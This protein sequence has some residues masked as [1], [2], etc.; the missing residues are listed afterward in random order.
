MRS[1]DS[2]VRLA[3]RVSLRT[4]RASERGFTITELLVVMVIIAVLASLLFP[5]LN[6]A[7][8]RTQSIACLN[9]LKQLQ[10]AWHMYVDDNDG[11][12]PANNADYGGKSGSGISWCPGNARTDVTTENIQRGLLFPYLRATDVYHCPGD[13]AKAETI[14]G[15]KLN[16]DRTRSY[17]MSGSINSDSA[18]QTIPTFKRFSD[19]INPPPHMVF[20]FLDVNEQSISDGRF[21]LYPESPKFEQVW[22]NMPSDRHNMG[23]NLSFADAHV[24]HWNWA[25]PKR[26]KSSKQSPSSYADQRDLQR[27]QNGLAQ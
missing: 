21:E 14:D 8:G 19:M 7:K 6:R 1:P 20:V 16:I 12:L 10:F 2:R 26:Y 24:E 4:H 23:G 18:G 9:N 22:V 11:Q 3:Q 27:M 5:A 15:E 17:S 13:K 25:A